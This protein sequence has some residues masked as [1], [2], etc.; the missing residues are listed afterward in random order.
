MA[1][2]Y[3][4]IINSIFVRAAENS[5]AEDGGI[6]YLPLTFI[7]LPLASHPKPGVRRWE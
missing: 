4:E 5:N 6:F 2:I 7:S 1:K 3:D